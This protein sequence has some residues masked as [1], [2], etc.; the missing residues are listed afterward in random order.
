VVDGL[1]GPGHGGVIVLGA[2]G[3]VA[4]VFNTPGMYRG[5]ADASGRFEIGV[6]E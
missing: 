5:A 1:L 3:D 6:W 4:F 2:E